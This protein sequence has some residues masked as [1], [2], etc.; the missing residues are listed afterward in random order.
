MI[1][2]L[3]LLVPYL[4]R[5]QEGEHPLT[6]ACNGVQFGTK[7]PDLHVRLTDLGFSRRERKSP[8]KQAVSAPEERAAYLSLDKG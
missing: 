3:R 2:A 7:H 1:E 4:R 8:L 5:E 6:L